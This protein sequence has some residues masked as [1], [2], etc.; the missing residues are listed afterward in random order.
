[1]DLLLGDPT[2]AHEKLGWK[3]TTTFHDLVKEMVA[4]DLVEVRREIERKNR[5]D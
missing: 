2:K 1:V 3:H 4:A 5:R